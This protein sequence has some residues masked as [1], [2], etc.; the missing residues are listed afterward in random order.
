MACYVRRP[1]EDLFRPMALDVLRIEGGRL[2][3]IV[4]F[5]AS[6]FAVFGLPELL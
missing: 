1:G 2:A 3:E 4:T 6:V 5:P